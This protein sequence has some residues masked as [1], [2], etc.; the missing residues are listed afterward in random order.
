MRHRPVRVLVF[1]LLLLL[2]AVLGAV[3]CDSQS[4]NP[5]E[6]D[7]CPNTEADASCFPNAPAGHSGTS[8]EGGRYV[9]CEP[10]LPEPPA[11]TSR[12]SCTPIDCRGVCYD[13][14][15]A[16]EA[17]C[18]PGSDG[19]APDGDTTDGDVQPDGDDPVD[20][21]QPDGDWPDGDDPDGDIP[22][23]DED[24]DVDGDI[25]GDCEEDDCEEDGDIDG[26]DDD[27]VD[28]PLFD[29]T[30]IRD[31]ADADCRF[32]NHRTVTKD[33]VQ[34]DLWDVSYVSYEAN[35][36]VLE[37]IV[38]RGY[39]ARPTSGSGGKLPGVVQAHGLGGWSEPNHATGTAALLGMFVLAYTGPGGAPPQG[40]TG[41]TSEG[42]PAGHDS[43]MRMFDTIPDP[44]G[45]WFW[46][47]A[48][49]GMR[50]L[51]C[52][53]NHSGVNAAKLGMTGYSAG[54][55]VTLISSAV[56]DRLVAAVPL[57]GTGAWDVATEAP[58]AW[59]HRLL[60]IAGLSTE[61]P[62]WTTLIENLDSSRLL[63]G[64]R[65]HILM[66]N[67]STDEFFP[68]TAH[69]ATYNAIPGSVTKRTSLAANMDH[70]CYQITGGENNDTISARAEIRAKGGQR[71]WFK[72]HFGTDSAYDYIPNA[73]IPTIVESGGVRVSVDNAAGK[74]VEVEK[75]TFWWSNDNG[76][77]FAG[78]ELSPAKGE[79]Q[80]LMFP[81]EK[82]TNTIY[83]V[84]VQY[85]RKILIT[86]K[87]SISSPPV[88]PIEPSQVSIRSIDTCTA[89]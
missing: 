16:G 15:Q 22:D 1:S 57:S 4:A 71:M 59:Q 37:P 67:G 31:A 86:E 55:V 25:D 68:L 63:S 26:D 7:S 12:C 39:A 49:A 13:L 6:E 32:T 50:G 24:G 34:L 78:Q 18:E 5:D 53:A 9:Y 74:G 19:D 44:R 14:E 40:T 35:D 29:Q 41:A 58:N 82:K 27:P 56:D 89:R 61:S 42:L 75:V 54:G 47:H 84:D 2:F 43:N 62:E 11:C 70:G 69:M 21:D 65:T 77:F 72:H 20:G 46:G 85:R 48:V 38:I 60:E 79:Y 33:L 51:T 8:C 76:F 28:P 52:L 83:F 73:P 3:S 30:L 87:F 88:I 64:T 10:T 23:G 80:A 36:G 81:F 17:V 45:S 66:V